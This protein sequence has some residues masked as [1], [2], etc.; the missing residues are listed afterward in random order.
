[1][2][3]IDFYILDETDDTGPIVTACKLCAKAHDEQ[4]KVFAYTLGTGFAADLD[5]ALWTFRQNSFISHEMQDAMQDDSHLASVIIGEK[6]PPE[7]HN[8]I[9][10]NLGEDVPG[11]FSRFERVLEIVHGNAEQRAVYRERFRFYKDRGYE[12]KSH[13]LGD[14]KK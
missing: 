6:K 2:T 3:R 11:F 14:V 7:S 4:K 5:S 10:L 8:N 13:K 12:L 1:M 9:M